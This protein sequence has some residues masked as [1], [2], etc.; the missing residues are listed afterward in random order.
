MIYQN[1]PTYLHKQVEVRDGDEEEWLMGTVM[2]LDHEG[3]L[4]GRP[5]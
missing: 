3:F 5:R 4:E 1:E 2:A